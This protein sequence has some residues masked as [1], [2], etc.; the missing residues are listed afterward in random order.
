[1]PYPAVL[2]AVAQLLISL[3]IGFLLAQPAYAQ[4]ELALLPGLRL[5][6]TPSVP[7][8]CAGGHMASARSLVGGPAVGPDEDLTQLSLEQ[9]LELE[10]T[11]INVLGSHT[12]LKGQ[13]MVAYQWM[14]MEMGGYRSGTETLSNRQVLDRFP[15]IHTGMTMQMH[16][17]ELMYAPS[18]R[19]TLMGMLPYK[20]M[21]MSHITRAGTRF[22]T[23]SS[24]F[25][26]LQFMALQTL[27]GNPRHHGTRILVNSGI[28]FPT[29]SIDKRD[30]TPT[31]PRAKLEY[32][33]QLGS[34][35]VDIMPGLTLL[36]ES[37][38][39][40]WGA[41]AL[42]TVRLGR[43]DNDYRFGNQARLN[44]WGVRKVTDWFAPSVRLDW[45]W[46]DRVH[47]QD[48]E[49]NPR[50]NPESNPRLQGGRRLDLML[51]LHLYAPRGSLK[52]TRFTIEGGFPLYQSLNGPQLETDWLLSL[53]LSRTF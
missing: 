26:D 12:H 37:R 41:Q 5:G 34:G 45:Q 38:Q 28:S 16:M 49:L 31:D 20:D 33:M 24:G 6:E 2:R 51:G 35:T 4:Q 13:W 40:A 1:M 3:G 10:I 15:T 36:G 46:W 25:G 30:R 8:A 39:W 17:L 44:M 7:L 19:L 23:R 32:P 52:G 11:T 42:G 21:S 47:G 29:G 14:L 43:N 53:G 9:L 18:D 48:P 22:D 50:G 27:G